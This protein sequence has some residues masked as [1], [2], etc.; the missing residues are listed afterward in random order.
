MYSVTVEGQYYVSGKLGG[1][2]FYEEKFEL[3]EG[4]QDHARAL[5][6]NSGL[7]EERLRKKKNFK[8]WQTCQVTKIKPID[9]RVIEGD[10]KKLEDLL[11][12]ATSKGCI[13]SDYK[14]LRSNSA[15][16]MKLKEALKRHEE[17]EQRMK[18][19]KAKDLGQLED[20]YV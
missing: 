5:I 11:L 20:G 6:Q 8:A 13:P 12:E 3:G 2:E 4:R 7:L 9:G 16:K 14:I 15:R 18:A 10:D 17:R 19:K 1:V